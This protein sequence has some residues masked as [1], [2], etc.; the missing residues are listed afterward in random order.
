M[1]ESN[2]RML[3]VWWI[4]GLSKRFLRTGYRR[5]GKK[6]ARPWL[7]QVL[8]ECRYLFGSKRTK[9]RRWSWLFTIRWQENRSSL[10]FRFWTF[11]LYQH[12][13]PQHS[14]RRLRRRQNQLP[15]ISRCGVLDAAGKLCKQASK[16][17]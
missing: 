7:R 15:P 11:R 1:L 17:Q 8:K 13:H 10:T 5:K 4:L 12:H 2:P 6:S 16:F 3:T 9:R 14:P